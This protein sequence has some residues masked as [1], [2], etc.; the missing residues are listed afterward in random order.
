MKV[1]KDDQVAVLQ[2]SSMGT[3]V[4]EATEVLGA[5]VECAVTPCGVQ[6]YRTLPKGNGGLWDFSPQVSYAMWNK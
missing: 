6:I 2:I 3:L 1:K 4:E 5:L